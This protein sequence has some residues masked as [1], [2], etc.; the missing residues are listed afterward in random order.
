MGWWKFCLGKAKHIW[1]THQKSQ[2]WCLTYSLDMKRGHRLQFYCESCER[3]VAFSILERD[4]IH[5]IACSGCGRKYRFEDET[6]IEQLRQFEAL[7][8]QIHASQAILGKASIAIDI[9]THHVKVPFN[10][11]L[12]R[13]SSVLDLNVG[14]KKLSIAFRVEPV[15][16]CQ[17]SADEEWSIR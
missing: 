14:G 10:L 6:L 15:Q 17:T 4:Y 16:D 7:C 8:R 1:Y 12:T 2:R 13:L 9:D 3:A 5:G 11:L